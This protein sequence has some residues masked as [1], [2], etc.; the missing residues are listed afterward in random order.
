MKKFMTM[1]LV[2]ALLSVMATTGYS[3]APNG[4]TPLTDSQLATISGIGFWSCLITAGASSVLVV[5]AGVATGGLGAIA[6][7]ALGINATRAACTD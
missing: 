2:L 4:T 5:A 3:I 1:S 7:G 6:A